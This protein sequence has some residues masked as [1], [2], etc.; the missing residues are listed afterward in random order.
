MMPR[1]PR[2][3]ALLIT[4]GCASTPAGAPVPLSVATDCNLPDS[5]IAEW[6][7]REGE[8]F[9]DQEYAEQTYLYAQLADNAY[10][11]SLK[12]T[13]PD[14]IRLVRSAEHE[15]TGFA[16]R[17][18]EFGK[19]GALSKVMI[20]YRGTE[21]PILISRDWRKGNWTTQQHPYAEALY[22]SVRRD[23]PEY[24]SVQ[25]TGHSLG[26]ALA[27]QVSITR[28]H[29]SAFAFNTSYR[30]K[31]R[32]PEKTSLRI[33]IQERGEIL[34]P[35]RWIL[36]NM[37]LRHVRGFNCKRGGP[38]DNHGMTALARCLTRA[39]AAR[40]QGAL[41]SLQRNPVSCR[42]ASTLTASEAAVRGE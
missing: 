26:G 2:T 39:A 38:I 3:L 27:L 4:L 5:T 14:T 36:P 18:Y 41:E 28:D 7:R 35:V 31:R 19:P 1:I 25:A 29:A 9:S 20:A 15:P 33:S 21:G 37:T 32:P 6:S 12:W 17:V 13:L 16:A 8:I 11:D 40:E 24:V 30:V 34:T 22:D 42:R 23:Y 10:P